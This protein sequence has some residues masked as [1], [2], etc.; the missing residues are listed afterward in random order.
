MDRE[1]QAS[2]A[3]ID[4]KNAYNMGKPLDHNPHPRGTLERWSWDFGW[5]SERDYT[6]RRTNEVAA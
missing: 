5:A 2:E 6:N 3:R 4:G 1:A